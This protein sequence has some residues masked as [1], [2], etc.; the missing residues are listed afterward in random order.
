MVNRCERS[1]DNEVEI[2]HS[3][4]DAKMGASQRRITE[5]GRGLFAARHVGADDTARPPL[6]K[7]TVEPGSQAYVDLI[8]HPDHEEPVL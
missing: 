7:I 5:I 3:Q 8:L 6:V 4:Q 2:V 1:S